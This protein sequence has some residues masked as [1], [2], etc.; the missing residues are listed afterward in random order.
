MPDVIHSTAVNELRRGFHGELIM[1]D[2]PSF[3]ENRTVFNAMI[4]RRPALIAQC[5]NVEDV[6]RAVNFG[7]EQG[8]EIAVR[9]GGH[10]VA[11]KSLSEGGLVIDLRRMNS[12]SV[13]PDVRTAKVSGGATMGHLDRATAAYGLATTGG[14]VSST[15]VGGYTLG[16]GDGW[17]ARYLG[18]ACDNLVEVELVTADGSLLRVSE[19][20]HGELFWALHGGGGNFGIATSLTFR[21]KELS[22]VHVTLLFWKPERGPEVI[23]AYRDFMEGAPDEFG[24]GLFYLTGPAEPF[25]PDALHGQLALAVLLVYA[26]PA[27]TAGQLAAPMLA[28]DHDGAMI[29][30]MPYVDF[31]CMLDDPPGYRNYWTAEYLSAFPDAAVNNFSKRASDMIVPSPSQHVLIP[32]GGAIDRGPSH[33]PLPWRS[34]PWCVHPF[35]LWENP[36]DDARGKKWARSIREEMKPWALDSVYLNFIGEEG[37]ERIIASFGEENYRRLAGVKATYD[38]ENLFR[39]NQNIKPR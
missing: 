17:L 32:Q 23:R 18:L 2:S 5:V 38:P 39:L 14:R 28:L 25:V 31:Q 20:E 29:T 7:R 3:D 36:L 33:Y 4:D 15:G 30:E 10:S 11:G 37:E 12:V 6:I 35:G 21:L 13:D 19:K 8:I 22:Q 16:G 24:G 27:D 26:G 1:P 9:G 34:A